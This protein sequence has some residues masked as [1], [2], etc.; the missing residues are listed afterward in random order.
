MVRASAAGS[1]NLPQSI[2][3]S[4]RDN[5]PEEVDAVFYILAE[6][7][8]FVQLSAMQIDSTLNYVAQPASSLAMTTLTSDPGFTVYLSSATR[9]TR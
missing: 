7:A 8:M 4:L 1:S 6:P 2:G 9:P 3:R 5:S